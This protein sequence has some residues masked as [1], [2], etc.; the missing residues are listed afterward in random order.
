MAL[1]RADT[2]RTLA[3]IIATDFFICMLNPKFRGAAFDYLTFDVER[4]VAAMIGTSFAKALTEKEL[5]I[6]G[7]HGRQIWDRWVKQ[8]GEGLPK[9]V[10]PP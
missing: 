2:I 7:Q 6:A 9:P 8:A 1:S 5:L 10:T 3:E 4:W